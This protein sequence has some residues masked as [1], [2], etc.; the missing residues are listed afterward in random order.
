MWTP[1]PQLPDLVLVDPLLPSYALKAGD[2]VYFGATFENRGTGSAGRHNLAVYVDG[3]KISSVE[4]PSMSPGENQT[5]IA[6]RVWYAT[7]GTHRLLTV[8][9]DGNKI[10][11]SNEVNNSLGGVF[12]VISKAPKFKVPSTMMYLK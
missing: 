3:A 8:I 6:T 11:E 2:P 4:V 9:D 10:S 12:T 1:K 5:Y 7:P